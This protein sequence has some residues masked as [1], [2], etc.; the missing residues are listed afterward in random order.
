MN[1]REGQYHG[2]LCGYVYKL[3]DDGR[4]MVLH[5]PSDLGSKARICLMSD[6]NRWK[7]FH[8]FPDLISAVM[9]YFQ[10]YAHVG[11]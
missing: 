1:I 11:N 4:C 5:C 7:T 2:G 6:G 3:R 9:H 10:H 8:W